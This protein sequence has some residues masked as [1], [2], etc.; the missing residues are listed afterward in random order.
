[1]EHKY[2][3]VTVENNVAVVTFHRPEALNALNS[4]V[5]AELDQT[6]D[7]LAADPAVRVIVFTGEGKSFIA[8]ADLDE[9][10]NARGFEVIE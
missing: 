6:I 9:L 4:A 8:G 7:V 2:L 10:G 5:L 1:M 3:L